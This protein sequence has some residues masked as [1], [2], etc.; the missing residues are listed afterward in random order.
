MHVQQVDIVLL[1]VGNVG[2]S[3][4]EILPQKAQMLERLYG[5]SLVIKGAC[6]SQGAVL[7]EEGLNPYR[8]LEC[9]RMGHSVSTY[10]KY[11]RPGMSAAELVEQVE[12]HLLV[13]A[14]PAS[15]KDGQP[16]LRCIARALERGWNVVTANKAPLVLAYDH[17]MSLARQQG[18]HL[19]FSGTCGGA[20]P[21]INIGWRDLAGCTIHRIEACLNATTTYILSRMAQGSSLEDAVSEAQDAGI[22]ETDP[23]LDIDGWDAAFKLV[24]LANSVLNIPTQL[25]DVEVTGIRDITP[26]DLAYAAEREETIRLLATAHQAGEDESYR[27]TVAPR[28]L[29]LDHPLGRTSAWEMGIVYHTDIAGRIVAIVEERGPGPTAAA[30]LRDIIDIYRQDEL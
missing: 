28:H 9:K 4:L 22:A 5:L 15:L 26:Q 18:R 25:H 27:F 8:L 7:S 17:L 1:G 13:E 14:T 10:P 20:L 16:G 6:D 29:P 24:I 21:S 12:A 19:R 23:S 3:L 2:Q 11:G 30:V